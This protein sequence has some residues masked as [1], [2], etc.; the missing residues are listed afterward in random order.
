M[1]TVDDYYSARADIAPFASGDS[2]ILQ[3]ITFSD[4]ATGSAFTTANSGWA[5]NGSPTW[6]TTDGV[7]IP[8]SSSLSNTAP[9]WESDLITA[10]EGSIYMEIERAGLATDENE[11]TGFQQTTGR[12]T[13]VIGLDISFTANNQ[14]DSAGAVDFTTI[15]SNGDSFFVES[16]DDDT[17]GGTYT[18]ST[19]SATQII[20]VETTIVAKTAVVAGRTKISS[21]D[22]YFILTT[23]T[24]ATDYIKHQRTAGANGGALKFSTEANNSGNPNINAFI[25]SQ[26]ENGFTAD[27]QKF[28][29]II[30]SWKGSVV[31]VIIDGMLLLVH[32]NGADFQTGAFN[33]FILGNQAPT[34]A[35]HFGDYFIRRLQISKRQSVLVDNPM[36]IG[37]IGDSVMNQFADSATAGDYDGLSDLSKL[38]DGTGQAAKKL[39]LFSLILAFARNHNMMLSHFRAGIACE[40]NAGWSSE[41]SNSIDATQ[42]NHII[43]YDPEILITAGSINDVN[44]SVPKADI[45][46]DTKTILDTIIDG[47]RSL[48]EI[49]FFEEFPQYLGDTTTPRNTQAYYDESKAHADEQ[50]RLNGYQRNNKAGEPCTVIFHRTVDAW[51]GRGTYDPDL[52]IGSASTNV[53]PNDNGPG[54]EVH[55]SPKGQIKVAE[56]MYNALKNS[57]A[58]VPLLR[59]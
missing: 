14:I 26:T 38:S 28:A 9:S 7:K 8:A 34:S 6:D 19:V 50:A 27:E 42:W 33:R 18:V 4:Y 5:V 52:T 23:S 40:S 36:K 1:A 16:D 11:L 49:H 31:T 51:G 55:P 22:I 57:I 41:I 2:D 32:D 58:S 46:T 59:D 53:A 15:L 13:S 43:S 45:Y 30:Y 10:N 44:P 12:T 56:I 17:N 39:G 29:R 25:N 54:N 47:C 35:G 20:T 37:I 3:D 24:T 21:Q 48:R